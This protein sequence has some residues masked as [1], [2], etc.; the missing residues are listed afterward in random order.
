MVTQYFF[1]TR[2]GQ[3]KLPADLE[4]GLKHKHIQTMGELDEYEER[5]VTHGISWL[6]SQT[7][8]WADL[9][10]WKEFHENLFKDVW[11]WAGKWRVH[12]LQNPDFHHPAQIQ[13]AMKQLEGDV[14]LWREDASIASKL[15]V[16]YFHER[17]VSIHPF[18]N[19]NGRW[20]RLIAERFAED[21]GLINPNWGKIF[22]KDDERR[23]AYLSAMKDACR[24]GKYNPLVLFM[25][26][27]EDQ[28]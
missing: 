14:K 25:W 11:T 9:L 20:G 21:L 18:A 6:K 15:K 17:L 16:A 7:K 1:K 2:D 8:P 13:L 12:E 4:K 26:S 23:H 28:K 22:I 19:G 3:T 10:F 24:N 27:P 5:N